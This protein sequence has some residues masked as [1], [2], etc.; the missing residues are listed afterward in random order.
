VDLHLGMGNYPVDAD[1]GI[2]SS[3]DITASSATIVVNALSHC[4]HRAHRVSRTPAI[5]GEQRFLE[6]PLDSFQDAFALGNWWK[7]RTCLCGRHAGNERRIRHRVPGFALPPDGVATPVLE[8]RPDGV[9]GSSRELRPDGVA[10]SSRELRPDA[11]GARQMPAQ[12]GGATAK[13]PAVIEPLSPDRYKVQFTASA[14]LR[15]K[16]E[17]LLALMSA[18]VAGRDLATVIDEAVTEKLARLEAKRFA[19][20]RS[21]RKGLSET[22]TS[23]SSRHI[24][25]RRQARRA[26]ARWRPMPLRG[27]ARQTMHRAQPAR[28]PPPAP[29][30]PRW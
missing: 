29:L 4:A 6:F 27:R 23:P 15:N 16:L 17:R 26:R 12:G 19:T 22:D 7:C 13:R 30:W 25:A 24:P 2:L 20:T 5:A 3:G 1:R 10:T 8:L 28:V 9:G 11:V 14:A 18:S 21:P